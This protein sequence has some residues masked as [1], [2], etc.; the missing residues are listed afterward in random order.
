MCDV[1]VACNIERKVLAIIVMGRR[2][3]THS[4]YARSTP[5]AWCKVLFEQHKCA[6]NDNTKANANTLKSCTRS[7][8]NRPRRTWPGAHRAL[9]K[10][11]PTNHPHTVHAATIFLPGASLTHPKL[12]YVSQKLVLSGW[13]REDMVKENMC[14][15]CL[16]R[17]LCIDTVKKNRNGKEV[18]SSSAIW[19]LV[20]KLHQSR[21]FSYYQ[22]YLLRL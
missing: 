17:M 12:Y 21:I 1:Y 16:C 10:T 7:T 8:T 15:G 14:G 22:K 18:S 9:P 3:E 20:Y 19:R 4:F 5:T 11:P 13:F 2:I 6:P